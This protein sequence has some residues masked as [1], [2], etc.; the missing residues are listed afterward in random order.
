MWAIQQWILKIPNAWTLKAIAKS[1][2]I[3]YKN[4]DPKK[5]LSKH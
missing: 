3:G 4:S 1:L 2:K 5:F